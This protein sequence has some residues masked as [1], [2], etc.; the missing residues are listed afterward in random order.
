[1][2][3]GIHAQLTVLAERGVVLAREQVYR[4][5]THA[6]QRMSMDVLVGLCDILEDQRRRSARQN[7]PQWGLV[8]LGAGSDGSGSC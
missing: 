5:A 8:D 4:M 3:P 1:M 2:L 7:Q 6:P